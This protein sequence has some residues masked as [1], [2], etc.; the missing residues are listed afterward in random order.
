MQVLCIRAGDLFL[1]VSFLFVSKI[2]TSFLFSVFWLAEL[3]FP[4][5]SD[6]RAFIP[7]RS[8]VALLFV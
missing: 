8:V 5:D 1:K 7:G 6:T 2:F 4:L 3:T